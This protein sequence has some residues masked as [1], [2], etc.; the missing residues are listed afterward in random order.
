MAH[1]YLENGKRLSKVEKTLHAWREELFFHVTMA[2]LG[3]PFG[4]CP[5]LP[6]FTEQDRQVPSFLTSVNILLKNLKS[7][8]VNILKKINKKNHSENIGKRAP[9]EEWCNLYYIIYQKDFCST[10]YSVCSL[11]PNKKRVPN[12]K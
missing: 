1:L 2:A 10:L 11:T 6:L 7:Q 3:W 8:M 4:L 5:L 12:G 9:S